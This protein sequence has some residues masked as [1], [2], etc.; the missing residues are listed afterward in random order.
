MKTVS[1]IALM[2]CLLSFVACASTAKIKL[3]T[4]NKLQTK[5]T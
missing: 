4:R 1:K 2:V 5:N 3:Q